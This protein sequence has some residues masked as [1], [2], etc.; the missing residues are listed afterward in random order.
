MTYQ[1]ELTMRKSKKT[2]IF[3]MDNH[4][5]DREYTKVKEWLKAEGVDSW[6]A[7]RCGK[8]AAID[9]TWEALQGDEP[10]EEFKSVR[11]TGRIL[12]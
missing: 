6:T 10:I 8:W 4:Y 3:P 2:Q 12:K 11:F 5:S 7:H 1:V 9:I